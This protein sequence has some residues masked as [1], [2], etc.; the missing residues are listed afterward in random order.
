MRISIIILPIPVVVSEIKAMTAVR[1]E[2]TGLILV[3]SEN[4]DALTRSLLD[5]FENQCLYDAVVKGSKEIVFK[6]YSWRNVAEEVVN[7]SRLIL[8]K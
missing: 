4:I 3:K 1:G 7:V 5:V 8:K 6:K 2:F